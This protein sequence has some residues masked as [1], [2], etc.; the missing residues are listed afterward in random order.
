[1]ITDYL[2]DTTELI[3][4]VPCLLECALFFAFASKLEARRRFDGRTAALAALLAAYQMLVTLLHQ[5]FYLDYILCAAGFFAY[6][7]LTKRSSKQQNLYVS[8]VFLL[9]IEAGK[10][11]AIDLLMQPFVGALPVGAPLAVTAVNFGLT[12]A[13]SALVAF[14][15]GRFLF[16]SGAENLSWP[17]CLSILLPLVPFMF[18]RS[19]NYAYEMTGGTL[20][21]DMVLTLLMLLGCTIVM[22]VVNA[23]NLSSVVKRAELLQMEALIQEQHRHY[24]TKKS[25]A[26]AVRRQYHD[27]KHYLG[28]LE[29]SQDVKQVRAFV[30]GMN[31]SI[32]PYET[33][34]ETGNEAVDIM[35][36]EKAA[37]CQRERIRLVPFVD[38][39]RLGFMSSFE[40]CAL[41]GN[42]LDN[43]IEATVPLEDD[44]LREILIEV[45]NDRGFVLVRVSNNYDGER[46]GKERWLATTKKQRDRHGFGMESIASIAEKRGGAMSYEARDG[47]FSLNVVIPLPACPTDAPSA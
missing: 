25:A 47:S 21:Q 12:F 11:V 5:R 32:V 6:L 37:W 29:S 10:I 4:Q 27:L 45:S 28:T 7:C 42:A 46:L 8:C 44:A 17:Q 9:C 40:L 33:F 36:A 34:V 19:Q 43:A 38:A 23:K 2:I 18:L 14:V 39:S 20:Y 31:R 15:V 1:M 24:A 16:E 22:I 26:D 30:D 35:L 3:W 41:F 13:V